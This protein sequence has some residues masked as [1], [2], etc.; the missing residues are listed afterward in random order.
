M[1]KKENTFA[2][3][4]KA[5]GNNIKLNRLQKGLSLERVGLD[6]GLDKSNMH[7]IEGGQNITL[8]T[9]IKIALILDIKPELLMKV[10]SLP[11]I[12]DLDNIVLDKQKERKKS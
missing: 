6:I 2:I 1:E 12:D 11:A 7:R 9:L 3:Y 4:L 10:E 8:L 5:V